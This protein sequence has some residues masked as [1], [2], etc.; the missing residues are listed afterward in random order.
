ML[1]PQLQIVFN[2]L[3]GSKRYG[4]DGS[5]PLY[6]ELIQLDKLLD[7]V[8][9]QREKTLEESRTLIKCSATTSGPGNYCS[10]CGKSL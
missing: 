9:V 6:Q 4:V 1:T 8:N 3:E 10:C 7:D 5:E 2:R